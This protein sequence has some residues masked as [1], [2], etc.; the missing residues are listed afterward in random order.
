MQGGTYPFNENF[1]R[2]ILA[3]TLRSTLLRD[4]PGCF[5]SRFFG[6]DQRLK[7]PM[8]LLAEIIERFA[9]RY[10]GERI[11]AAV[12][13]ELVRQQAQRMKP[14]ERHQFEAEWGTIRSLEVANPDYV[15]DRMRW[16]ARDQ[17]IRKAI[18]QSSELIGASVD[19]GKEIDIAAIQKLVE[20]ASGVGHPYARGRMIFGED[21]MYMWRE[22]PMMFQVTTGYRAL[23]AAMDGGPRRKEVMYF[24]APPKG[25]KTAALINIAI[26]A[27]RNRK[28]VAY[29]SFEMGIRPMVMRMHRN[30]A[31]A[32]KQEL[33]VNVYPLR[34]AM[35]AMQSFGVKNIWIE[36]YYPQK[37]GCAEVAKTVEH[38]RAKG[39][40]IDV[41]IVDYLNIMSPLQREQEKRHALAA[42]SREIS[43][44]AHELDVVV[45]SAALVKRSAV[46]KAV[47]RKVDIAEAFEVISV[48]DGAIAIC[49]PA[50]MRSAGFRQL[51]LT[52]LRDNEDEKY[53]GLYRVDMDRMR[54]WEATPEEIQ[55]MRQI[56]EE[57]DEDHPIS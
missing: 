41:V 39:F 28:G 49:G 15:M 54:I 55:H 36:R 18:T 42:I 30:I 38:L 2:Q 51:Y 14:A 4:L 7:S 44:M 48:A 16:W 47:V 11:D 12:M 45:W 19:S 46:D 31:M 23:D 10:Q 25:A 32:T 34:K 20:Q 29:F 24:L 40:E 50:D 9:L 57:S 53:A 33:R 52:A 17:A 8:Q 3:L 1:Q 21:G 26:N 37:Q 35:K 5:H 27:S 43:A 56:Q 13:D 6:A 22:T